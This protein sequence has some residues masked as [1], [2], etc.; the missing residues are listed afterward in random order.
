MAQLGISFVQAPASEEG[1]FML[2]CRIMAEMMRCVFL[3]SVGEGLPKAFEFCPL[4][5]EKEV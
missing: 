2:G 5:P 4:K 1:L 3:G